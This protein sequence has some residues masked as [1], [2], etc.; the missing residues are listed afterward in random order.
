VS[1]AGSN[2][3]LSIVTPTH[4]RPDLLARLLS[5][6]A[7]QTIDAT[8]FEVVVVDDASGD[9]T[10]SILERWSASHP[11]LRWT[12][13]ENGRGPA[14]ARNRGVELASGSIVLFLD[15]D[16]EAAP[17][18]VATHMRFHDEAAD[19]ALGLLGRVDWHP[20]LDITPFMRWLDRSGLQFAYDTW[21]RPGLIDPPYGA[22]YTA[23]LSMRRELLV[24]TGGFDERFPYPAY[25][26]MELAWR[27]A[28]RGF[29]L[30][31]R[32]EARVFHTRAI[33]LQTFRRRMAK[34]AESAVVLTAVQPDFPVT[35]DDTPERWPIP[36]RRQRLRRR[37]ALA[38][39]NNERRRERH[40]RDEI[41]LAYR[42][43]LER[44]R[45]RLQN[46]GDA[47]DGVVSDP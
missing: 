19:G 36:T 3:S 7:E 1:I 4:R 44:G 2:P 25:E 26:D 29:R 9:D 8:R 21:M 15:D 17:D 41:A 33:D 20:D 18:L 27:L 6:L 14:A 31:Y 37:V 42:D 30:E 47:E 5:S 39:T 34:V 32:P 10:P 40:F 13:F 43:G 45:V 16:V 24:A 38:L 22:F 12:S 35:P 11:T 28:E 46:R 23:N